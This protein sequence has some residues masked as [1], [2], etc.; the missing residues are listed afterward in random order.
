MHTS[1]AS[2]YYLLRA[3]VL[4]H[5]VASPDP[6]IFA[7]GIPHVYTQCERTYLHMR[8]ASVDSLGMCLSRPL[9]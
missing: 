1:V 7:V 5:Y 3:I 8:E 6:Y 4:P 9:A 2:V